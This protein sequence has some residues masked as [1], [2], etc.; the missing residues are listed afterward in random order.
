MAVDIVGP[1]NATN[2][3]TAR[4][5]DTR[6]FGVNDT[7]FKDCTSAINNDGT[8]IQA[9]WL[10]AVVGQFRN[11]I[12]GNGL[13]VASAVVVAEDNSDDMLLNSIKQ[14]IQRGQPLYCVDSGAANALVVAPS[15]A[16]AEYKAGL[17]L[18][19]KINAASTGGSTINVSGLGV[20]N[21]VHLDGSAIL[22]NDFTVGMLAELGFDGTNFQTLSLYNIGRPRLYA[23][24]DYYVNS[25]LGNDAN[26]G[27][28]AGAGRAFAT[29]QHAVDVMSNFDNNGF[30]VLIHVANG[31]Y[32]G[33]SLPRLTGSGTVFIIG[34]IGSPSSCFVNSGSGFVAA[35]VSG[36]YDI[37]GFRVASVGDAIS[38]D[39][40][41]TL[42]YLSN[43]DFNACAG[44]AHVVAQRGA[45]V[46]F[47]GAA[48]G[49]ASPG[50]TISGNCPSHL[51]A[52]SGGIIDLY[53]Q[54]LT[55]SGTPN[56]S[57][58]F[59]NCGRNSSISSGSGSMYSSISGSATGSRYTVIQ[60]GV[61][62]T[63]GGGANYFPGSSAGSAASGGQYL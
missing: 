59:A 42:I 17:K 33:V 36:T 51:L 57:T 50:Y 35:G 3:V 58:A 32:A 20:K 30:N 43:M 1:A 56:F 4:P 39:L 29:I 38:A 37:S 24:R 7:F 61:I 47:K 15:P 6:T 41:G 54:V 46:L 9:G 60:N 25:A 14:M 19:V 55:F 28:A 53:P 21:I 45:V 34:N 49:V 26:D 10:N 23:A 62:D 13:T 12:R 2:S 18:L 63:S 27:L 44:P 5:A 40:G 11:A 48:H 8:K 52:L 31:N 16:V 22:K